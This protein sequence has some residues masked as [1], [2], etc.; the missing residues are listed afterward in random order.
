MR[1]ATIVMAGGLLVSLAACGDTTTERAA[2]GGVG[3]LVVAGPV[4]AVAGATAGAATTK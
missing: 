4:G 3:G 2:T 1:I